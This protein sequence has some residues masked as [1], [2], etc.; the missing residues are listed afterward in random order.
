MHGS[1][2]N[3]TPTIKNVPKLYYL[4]FLLLALGYGF[5]GTTFTGIPFLFYRGKMSCI[6]ANNNLYS[7]TTEQACANPY[8]F[9]EQTEYP[10]IGSIVSLLD[11]YCERRVLEAWIQTLGQFGKL[12][13]YV[14][15]IFFPVKKQIKEYVIFGSFI[16]VGIVLMSLEYFQ[17]TEMF[18][19]AFFIWYLLFSVFYGLIYTHITDVYPYIISENGSAYINTSWPGIMIVFIAFSY[20]F[21]TWENILIQF[22]GIPLFLIGVSSFALKFYMETNSEYIHFAEQVLEEQKQLQSHQEIPIERNQSTIEKLKE[23]YEDVKKNKQLRNNLAIWTLGWTCNGLCYFGC[24][25]QLNTLQG[26]LYFNNLMSTLFEVLASVIAVIIV[27]RMNLKNVIITTYFIIGFSF[28][29]CI[30]VSNDLSQNPS[31]SS[32]II[33]LSPV[34][35]AKVSYEIMW[36]V[37]IK[38]QNTVFATKYHQIQFSFSNMVAMVACNAIPFY[39]YFMEQM[40]LSPFIGYGLFCLAASYFSTQFI[41][42]EKGGQ[43][44][45]LKEPLKKEEFQNIELEEIYEMDQKLSKVQI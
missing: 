26:N 12:L 34:V 27:M 4:K 29:S 20:F 6:D 13:A 16:I 17:Q 1:G 21:G 36:T 5:N 37:L 28:T 19:I 40:N 44:E 41:E 45:S 43:Q 30:F 11:L 14:I 24:Y 18:F 7:C 32:L 15:L 42:L 39:K 25:F 33:N 10:Q 22:T 35:V 8:G 3:K 2:S 23:N 9:V 38:Y 31:F